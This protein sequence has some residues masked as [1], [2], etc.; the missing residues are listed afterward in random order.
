MTEN[1][2]LAQ[3]IYGIIKKEDSEKL[4]KTKDRIHVDL[5]SDKSK[6]R[7]P[8]LFHSR[9]YGEDRLVDLIKKWFEFRSRHKFIYN[10]YVDSLYKSESVELSYFKSV[11]FLEGYHR[12]LLEAKDK[13]PMRRRKDLCFKSVLKMLEEADVE[14]G[15]IKVVKVFLNR[16]GN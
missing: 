6:I 9:E 14:G 7:T 5:K 11:A 15:E 12:D 2:V 10:F 16:P 1:I 8:L 3:S 13:S 4:V